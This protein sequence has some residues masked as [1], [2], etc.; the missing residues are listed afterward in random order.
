MAEQTITE[1]CPC[2]GSITYPTSGNGAQRQATAEAI[3]TYREEHR[4]HAAIAA[5][6]LAASAQGAMLRG[7]AGRR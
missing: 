2:G 6:G 1:T 5:A 3:N 7:F 4:G